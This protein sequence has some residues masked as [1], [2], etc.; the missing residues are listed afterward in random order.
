MPFLRGRYFYGCISCVLSLHSLAV[1][2]ALSASSECVLRS[3][4]KMLPVQTS[5]CPIG[6]VPQNAG[7]RIDVSV[8]KISARK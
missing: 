1:R 7:G 4:E 5:S 6:L 2:E 3:E 8:G